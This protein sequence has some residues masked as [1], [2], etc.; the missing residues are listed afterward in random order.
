[1]RDSRPA[2][3]VSSLALVVWFVVGAVQAQE[4]ADPTIGEAASEVPTDGESSVDELSRRATD[5]TDSPT[6]F[7]LLSDFTTDYYDFD[8]GSSPD[9]TRTE[10]KL[11][12]VLP[13]TAWGQAQILRITVPYQA[14]GQPMRF[15]INP[16]YQFEDP[17]GTDRFS[18]TVEVP[19]LVPGGA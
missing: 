7:K 14:A 10:L 3:F 18:V 16:Q 4:A 19:V 17:P 12:P 13:F 6:T 8:D 9:G 5:P 2:I 11:Q 1:M 15:G